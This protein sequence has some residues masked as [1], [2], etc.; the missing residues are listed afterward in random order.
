MG[1]PRCTFSRWRSVLFNLL[2]IY[3]HRYFWHAIEVLRGKYDDPDDPGDISHFE[4]LAVCWR[5]R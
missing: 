3:P 5:Q 4:A 1:P 2:S